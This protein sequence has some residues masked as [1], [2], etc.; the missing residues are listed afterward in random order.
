ME[1]RHYTLT[2]VSRIF[3]LRIE[4]DAQSSRCILQIPNAWD[5][6]LHIGALAQRPDA[7]AAIIAT[8]ERWMQVRT[9]TRTRC[10]AEHPN[11]MMLLHPSP[12]SASSMGPYFYRMIAIDDHQRTDHCADG[13]QLRNPSQMQS[14]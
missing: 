6:H 12:G 8:S 2:I 3:S 1:Q 4:N 14:G 7:I 10:K 13:V 11:F 5:R 9:D